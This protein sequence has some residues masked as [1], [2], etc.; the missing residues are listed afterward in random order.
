[1]RFNLRLIVIFYFFNIVNG[2]SQVNTKVITHQHLIW[3]GYFNTI[4]WNNKWFLTS[5]IQERHY[6]SPAKQHQFLVRSYLHFKLTN[7]GDISVGYTQFLQS[8]HNPYSS[9]NLMV[10]ESRPHFEFNLKNTFDKIN[11][12]H[13]YRAE[14]R[15]FKNTNGVE[16]LDGHWNYFR[17]RYR[18]GLEIQLHKNE[19]KKQ[20]LYL[21][22]SD[23]IHLNAGKNVG[24]NV[25]DQ[26]R[27]YVGLN[28]QVNSSLSIEC[29]YMNWFQQ[30]FSG[31]EFYNRDI[32]RMIVFH[33]INVNNKIKNN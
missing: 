15:F 12:T 2:F 6:Y 26:N 28:L 33:K 8:P 3:Y 5:E 17:F 10:P 13:R 23:E 18:L 21:K 25:F 27:I 22:I 9:L 7:S 32:M 20:S 16:L 24:M 4:N 11:F 19:N 31:Y 1:M 29:G 14:W 30:G